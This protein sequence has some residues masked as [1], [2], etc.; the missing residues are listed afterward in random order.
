MCE[1]PRLA[2]CR[3]HA[4]LVQAPAAAMPPSSEGLNNLISQDQ[5]HIK[6]KGV[7]GCSRAKRVPEVDSSCR[8]LIVP[9]FRGS[10][11]LESLILSHHSR[12][13]RYM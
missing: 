7:A 8:L 2:L 11:R 1:V 12:F 5:T 9:L 6:L 13:Q 10:S 3:F 4:G